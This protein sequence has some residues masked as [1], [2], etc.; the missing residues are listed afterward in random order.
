MQKRCQNR[1]IGDKKSRSFY[2]EAF[3]GNFTYF[4][5]FIV[6]TIV[7]WWRFCSQRS[8]TV[9]RLSPLFFPLSDHPTLRKPGPL[10]FFPLKDIPTKINDFEPVEVKWG[11]GDA[12]SSLLVDPDE[13]GLIHVGMTAADRI[14]IHFPSIDGQEENR[15]LSGWLQVGDQRRPLPVGHWFDPG[16]GIFCWQPGFCFSGEYRLVFIEKDQYGTVARKDL[17]V[18]VVPELN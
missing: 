4:R 11:Y 16:K 8:L 1:Q 9:S 7:D 2:E 15:N 10:P 12:A 3:R 6:S 13:N 17:L 14:E 5:E 18:R